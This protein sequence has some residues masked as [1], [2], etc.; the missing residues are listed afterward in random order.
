MNHT[1]ASMM[2]RMVEGG[3]WESSDHPEGLYTGEAGR[4]WAWAVVDRQLEKRFLGY[5]DL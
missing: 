3:V 5:N 4:A 1:T 2:A